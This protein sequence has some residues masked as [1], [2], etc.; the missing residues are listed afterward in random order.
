MEQALKAKVSL[1][2][3]IEKQANNEVDE[4]EGEVVDLAKAEEGDIAK[5]I[6][7]REKE[8]FNQVEVVEEQEGEEKGE[9]TL[10]LSLKEGEKNDKSLWYLDNGVTRVCGT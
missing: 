8:A 3:N 7:T 9:S 10:L 4:D 1:T 5:T 6:T 2:E